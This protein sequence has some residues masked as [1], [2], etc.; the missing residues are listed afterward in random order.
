MTKKLL[1]ALVL[2]GSVGVFLPQQTHAATEVGITAP[3]TTDLRITD[4]PAAQ[5]LVGCF[6]SGDTISAPNNISVNS[7][8]T[9][10]LWDGSAGNNNIYSLGIDAGGTFGDYMNAH[11]GTYTIGLIESGGS[12]T[13]SSVIAGYTYYV[14]FGWNNGLI[15]DAYQSTQILEVISPTYDE[16]ST[17]TDVVF[18]YTYYQPSAENYYASTSIRIV[19]TSTGLETLG[20]SQALIDGIGTYYFVAED[21]IY[22]HPYLWDIRIEGEYAILPKVM[23]RPFSVIEAASSTY[24]NGVIGTEVTIGTST[25]PNIGNFLSF[26]NVPQLLQNKV[27]F[28]YFFQAKD[29]IQRGISSS[30]ADE[31][32][33]GTFSVW[34]IGNATTTVD[35]FSTSTI[36]YFIDD[37][38][39]SMLRTLML[40]IMY[41]EV[42][43]LFYHRGRSQHII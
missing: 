4:G 15:F 10:V 33:S 35:L 12:G 41:I 7:G 22:G 28:G 14:T 38:M 42:L 34:G 40:W 21:L 29:A 27:P 30:T 17:T 11:A 24:S 13:C 1:T 23:G 16:V 43:Y 9:Y 8:G 37:D 6:F 32:P 26:L 19:D 25:L 5:A 2:L 18:S 20:T 36:G 31:I 39:A 3:N